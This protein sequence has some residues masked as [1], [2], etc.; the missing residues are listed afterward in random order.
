FTITK[1]VDY[2]LSR[3]MDNPYMK[4][5]VDNSFCKVEGIVNSHAEELLKQVMTY[6][7]DIDAEKGQLFFQLKSARKN[8][9][10]KKYHGI[11]AKIKHLE[12]NEY[13]CLYKD[14]SFPT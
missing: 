10:W 13:V 1:K 4:L 12:E 14:N 2:L 7:N 11:K 6:K 9:D 8:E 5:V 3:Y